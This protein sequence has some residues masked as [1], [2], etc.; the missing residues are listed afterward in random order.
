MVI[1]FCRGTKHKINKW[2]IKQKTNEW[3]QLVECCQFCWGVCAKPLYFTL[4]LFCQCGIFVFHVSQAEQ[5]N[6]LCCWRC[7]FSTVRYCI[8]HVKFNGVDA[9]Q[10]HQDWDFTVKLYHCLTRD[11]FSCRSA[12]EILYYIHQIPL[13]RQRCPDVAFMIRRKTNAQLQAR[14]RSTLISQYEFCSLLKILLWLWSAAQ[15]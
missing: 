3:D 9:K 11:F 12:F 10:S 15:Q 5:W 14:G 8:A 13:K 2:F 4:E 1:S 6:P 7:S